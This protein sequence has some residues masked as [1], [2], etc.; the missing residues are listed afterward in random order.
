MFTVISVK[1]V[2]IQTAIEISVAYLSL[3]VTIFTEWI[4][5]SSCRGDTTREGRL[6]IYIRKQT[7][8]QKLRKKQ[9]NYLRVSV[10]LNF[11]FERRVLCNRRVINN[12]CSSGIWVVCTGILP[13]AGGNLLADR[14][15]AVFMN[16]QC[17]SEHVAHPQLYP[18]SHEGQLG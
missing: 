2:N 18:Q 4:L 9:R 8:L 5:E 17:V 14:F 11:D 6:Y 15:N 13:L 3:E 12:T 10:T 16:R 1:M 7:F